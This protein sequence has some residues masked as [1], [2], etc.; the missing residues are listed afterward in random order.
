MTSLLTLNVSNPPRARAE[1]LLHW[2]W[3]REEDLWVLTEVGR[4]EGSNLLLSVC[5]AAGFA[6]RVTDR[7]ELGVMTVARVGTLDEATI[8][9]PSLLPGRVDSVL[10]Q[11]DSHVEPIRV[12]ATY[13][14]ASDPVRYASK[15]QRERKRQWLTAYEKV[16]SQW[17]S[18]GERGIVLGDLNLVDPVHDDVLKYVLTEETAMYHDLSERHGLVDAFRAHHDDAQ[19]SWMDHSGV[20]CRYDHAFATPDLVVEASEL[21]HEPRVDGLTDHSALTVTLD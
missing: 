10:W 8:D 5:R 6:I 13:G 9:P 15:A 1:S 3:P 19:M 20:G 11:E 7:S 2:L 4:G 14:V 16:V 17:V 12:L 18:R 21:V